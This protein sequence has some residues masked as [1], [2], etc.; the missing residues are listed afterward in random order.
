M[1]A[2]L[3]DSTGLIVN[4]IVWDASCTAPEGTT[5]HVVEDNVKVAP[6]YTLVNGEFVAPEPEPEPEDSVDSEEEI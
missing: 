1:K 4:V 2:A 5:P 6:G 3:A